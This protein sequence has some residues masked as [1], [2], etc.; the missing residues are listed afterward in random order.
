VSIT[1]GAPVGEIEDRILKINGGDGKDTFN[2]QLGGG[3]TVAASVNG[4]TTNFDLADIDRIEIMCG[5]GNDV[6]TAS[7]NLTTPIYAF[8]D[9]GN[10]SLTGGGGMDT[11]TGAAGRNFLDGGPGDDRVNGSGANDTLFGS[12]GAD[13]LYGNGG[14]DQFEGGGGVD[15]VFA[16]D[17]N[18]FA[19]GGGSNDKL[20]GEAGDDTLIGKAGADIID[21]AAGNDSREDDATDIVT[22]VENVV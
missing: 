17:G 16:G 22:S 21:G 5:A 2:L 11:L 10:D 14:D 15:R 12:D 1:P 18:D 6:L 20:Y 9:A 3:G 19:V 8:G 4:R 7:V 13:R